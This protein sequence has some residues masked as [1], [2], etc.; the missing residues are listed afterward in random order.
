MSQSK[1]WLREHRTDYYVKK[2]QQEGYPSR[3]AYKLLEIQQK[4]QLI[5]PGMVVIDLGAAPGG[6]S[7]VARELVGERGKVIALDLL[8]M[9]PISGV[10]FLQGDFNDDNILQK[11]FSVLEN[12]PVDLVISDMA[13]NISGQKSIDQ[14]R[15]MH[16]V[17]LAWDF[18]RKVL[19]EGGSFLVK[20]FQ[21]QGVDAFILELRKEFKT[22]KIRKPKSSRARSREVYI[23]GRDFLGYNNNK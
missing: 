18:A 13:P 21:G 19:K 14:P 1:R 17:E 22:V 15:T 16:L 10:T 3:A 12:Q 6:W 4:D 5:K 9:E 20:V 2:S 23:L 7:K 8:P 11:L